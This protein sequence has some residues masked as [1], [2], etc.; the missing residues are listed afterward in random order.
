[1]FLSMRNTSSALVACR[2]FSLLIQNLKGTHIFILSEGIRDFKGIL[3]VLVC[4]IIVTVAY[5]TVV[6][7]A[8]LMYDM[9]GKDKEKI[10]WT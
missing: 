10:N 7:G 2:G 4:K 9:K 5:F 1:M 3:M 8:R 6:L